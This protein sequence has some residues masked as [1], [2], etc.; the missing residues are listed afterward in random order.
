MT[1]EAPMFLLLDDAAI[2]WLAPKGD[3]QRQGVLPQGRK[4]MEEQADDWLQTTAKKGVAL[5]VSTHSAEKILQSPLGQIMI[6]SCKHRYYLPNPGA[7][8]KHI[9]A[10]Y[11]EMGLTETAIQ[12][13]AASR[14]QRD[15]Y[16]AHEELGQRLI[17][18]AHGPLTL[19]CIA[20]NAAEDHALMD[21]LLQQEGREGF[22]AA[23]F[24]HHGYTDAASR[25]AA[26]WQ[27]R[28]EQ[29][30]RLQEQAAEGRE[31]D[32]PDAGG[33]EANEETLSVGD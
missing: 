22:A 26:W 9:R 12:T 29:E 20:R 1:T 2:A 14:P 32:D 17:S 23:W 28:R 11:E 27:Q 6:E 16:Y 5:G 19:D 3:A 31:Q 8:E 7:M 33:R 10:V 30:T 25:V 21:T 13:I 24:R 18:L 15:V 4:T